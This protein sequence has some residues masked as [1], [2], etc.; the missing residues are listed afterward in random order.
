MAVSGR[1]TLFLLVIFIW[2]PFLLGRITL[3]EHARTAF[4]DTGGHGWFAGDCGI[5]WTEDGGRS[6]Q[7]RNPP[8]L[9]VDSEVPW[10]T[11][12]S[13]PSPDQVWAVVSWR[14]VWM[15]QDMGLHWRDVT[16]DQY[17][18][19]RAGYQGLQQ[20]VSAGRRN[21]FL[22]DPRHLFR[23]ADQGKTWDVLDLDPP[24]SINPLT[25]SLMHFL[26]A[27]FGWYQEDDPPPSYWIT[28]DGGQT[29]DKMRRGPLAAGSVW[30]SID[31]LQFVTPKIGYL[32]LA[33]S[34]QRRIQTIYRTSDAGQSWETIG[35]NLREIHSDVGL[36]SE[37]YP[38][39][40]DGVL[41]IGGIASRLTR[42]GGPPPY[43]LLIVLR[44]PDWKARLL[45][46]T[47]AT[48]L[49]PVF[50]N[51]KRGWLFVSRI[52]NFEVVAT[53]DGGNTWHPLYRANVEG[54]L[55]IAE[56]K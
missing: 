21:A 26:D 42:I 5:F 34:G 45:Y 48:E 8:S 32:I 49:L 14:Q 7:P 50:A 27:R 6:W 52:S 10:I 40:D 55:L 30:T 44:P 35:Q 31:A 19:E 39:P 29:W 15:T 51:K 53:S 4:F 33:D 22:T 3:G 28:R 1:Y 54:D 24:W 11:A 18:S 16:P 41:A 17:R 37:L 46:R 12:A 13:G 2:P 47:R 38:I 9:T 25:G 43:H 36:S 20:V 56:P 23:S